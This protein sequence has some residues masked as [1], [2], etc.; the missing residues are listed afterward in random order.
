MNT[1]LV[2]IIIPTRNRVEYLKQALD[3]VYAQ[4]Y[5]DFEVIVVD[6]GSTD[7]TSELVQQYDKRL[8]YYH[9]Y[10]QGVA[11]A[12]NYG[13]RHAKG[14]WVAFLDDDDL[15][16]PGKLSKNM[17]YLRSHPDIIWLCS[18]FQL[19]DAQAQPLPREPIVPPAEITLHEIAMFSFLHT[20]S[21]VVSASVL[22]EVGGFPE[23]VKVSE[24]YHVWAKLLAQ[25]KGGAMPEVLTYFRQHDNNTAL[26]FWQLL[27]Q[28]SRIIDMIMATQAPGLQPRAHYRKNLYRI[29][30]DSL[31]YKKHYAAYAL[32]WLWKTLSGN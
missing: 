29:V 27:R 28:N 30:G 3:S 5:A 17:A 18:G 20:S 19:V 4:D 25:G 24:D 7:T 22:R 32:F 31:K 10:H 21:V 12:R 6:D 13:I 23:G 14:R 1:D 9:Q 26:P 8:H 16:L 15:F 11:A 2:S